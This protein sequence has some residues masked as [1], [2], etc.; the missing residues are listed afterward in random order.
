M[1]GYPVLVVHDNVDAATYAA[2]VLASAGY[3]V[4][5]TRTGLGAL[6]KAHAGS[7]AAAVIDVDLDSEPDGVETA[8]WLQRLYSVPSVVLGM[9]SETE[10]RQRLSTIGPVRYLTRPFPEA[11]L[12][13]AV[14]AASTVNSALE[15]VSDPDALRQRLLRAESGG[16]GSQPAASAVM[17]QPPI[18]RPRGFAEL[19]GREWQIVRDLIETPSAQAVALKRRRSHHTVHNHLKSIFRKLEVHSIA[20]LLSLM[21]RVSPQVRP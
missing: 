20:E 12:V 19:S 1:S 10:L 16:T 18:V 13:A 14:A 15:F 3:V 9:A 8:D 6:R 17:V 21:L 5:Q 4:E 7:Y 2:Q 11:E